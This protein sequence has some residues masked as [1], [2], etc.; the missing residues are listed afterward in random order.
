MEKTLV[1]GAGLSGSTVARLLAESG[2]SVIVIDKRET[3]GGNAYDY[4]DKNQIIIQP[5]GPHIF[6]TNHKEVF[7]FL[8][9]F[10]DWTEYKHQVVAKIGKNKFVPVPFNLNSLEMVYDKDK[11]ERIKKVLIEQIGMGNSMP[12]LKL[13]EHKNQEIR[14][15][16]HLIYQLVFYSYT[17][18]QWGLKPEELGETVMNRVPV[19]ISY[20]NGYFSDKYQYMP[21]N[22]FTQ[23]ISNML[24][25]P[26]IQLKLGVD[27]KKEIA[28]ENGKIYLGGQEF[29]GKLIYTGCVDELFDYQ[30]GALPYRSLRFRFIRKRTNSFQPNAV[31][32]YTVN[33][34]YTRISEFTKFT[35]QQKDCTVIVKEFPKPFRKGK[36]IPY[37]PI[38]IE[39]NQE[40]YLKYLELAKGYKKLYLL[41]RL[42]NYKYINMDV[43]VKNAMDLAKSF[44]E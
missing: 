42:A 3:I 36:N 34:R 16:A 21:E 6:H 8:S 15:L 26:N 23:M 33:K 44:V 28:L 31:V 40:H 35:C 18:K 20:D 32:N 14:E 10:T 12:V 2:E 24:R 41:G 5:Y 9:R 30:F 19:K 11:A 22:G 13:F 25:H 27:A 1:V 7:E 43:A 4:Q 17:K 29:K 39:K 37:Y 38:P